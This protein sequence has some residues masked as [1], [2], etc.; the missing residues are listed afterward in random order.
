MIISHGGAVAA[1]SHPQADFQMIISHG[2]TVAAGGHPQ[3]DF[4]MIISHGGTV[5]AGEPSSSRLPNDHQS[6]WYSSC[7]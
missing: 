4:Q 2:G 1:G 6:W 7:W 3:A 5:A